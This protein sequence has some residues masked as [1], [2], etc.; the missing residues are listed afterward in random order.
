[1]DKVDLIKDIYNKQQYL[2][3]IKTEFEEL[4]VKSI[5][6]EL[7][8]QISVEEFFALYDNLFY[9]IPS[10]GEDNSHE[11]LVKTSGEYI[12]FDQNL[13][14]IEALRDEIAQLR[15]ELLDSQMENLKLST[16]GQING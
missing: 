7:E 12:N 14:E 15:K 9:D 3:T 16:E 13:E 2:K 11:Y 5:Q 4:G 6:T 8:E 10:N 1:M